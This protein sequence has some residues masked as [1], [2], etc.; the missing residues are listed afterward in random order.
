M[1]IPT[2]IG[3]LRVDRVDRV[4]GSQQ[5]VEQEGGAALHGE[6]HFL[7]TAK[8][9]EPTR[10]VGHAGRVVRDA[11]AGD[12]A[13]LLI[14]ERGI[15]HTAGPVD[16][17]VVHRVLPSLPREP[18]AAGAPVLARAAQLL[19]SR[20]GPGRQPGEHV[21]PETSWVVGGN[22]SVPAVFPAEVHIRTPRGGQSDRAGE[23]AAYPRPLEGAG[24][25]SSQAR[26]TQGRIPS[27]V[28]GG[29]GP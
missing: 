25:P 16:P 15:V 9:G 14:E 7:R 17:D 22:G 18:Q 29:R 12:H 28:Q 5:L 27:S 23:I 13:A 24:V 19:I 11:P 2:A 6:E 26:S 3:L 8:S 10:E 1:P 21:P 20:R 4:A